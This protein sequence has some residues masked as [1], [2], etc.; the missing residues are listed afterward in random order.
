MPERLWSML[1]SKTPFALDAVYGQLV[2]TTSTAA[3]EL[4]ALVAGQDADQVTTAS[5]A[6][7]A[8][9]PRIG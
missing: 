8:A 6:S 2:S 9:W 5:S 3:V 7:C 1:W 4:L